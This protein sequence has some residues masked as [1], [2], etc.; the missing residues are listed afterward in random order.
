MNNEQK[1]NKI[2]REFHHT[3]EIAEIGYQGKENILDTLY[4]L[5]E[6]TK[7]PVAA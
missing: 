3:D 1:L 7:K 4:S 5:A 2:L 6:N